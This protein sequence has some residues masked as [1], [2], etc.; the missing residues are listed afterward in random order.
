[1]CSQGTI[2]VD[3]ELR[4]P[5]EVVATKPCFVSLPLAGFKNDALGLHVGSPNV[6]ER[7]LA[8]GKGQHWWRNGSGGKS[9]ALVHRRLKRVLE[10]GGSTNK[11]WVW[12]SRWGGHKGESGKRGNGP[13]F[14]G[15]STSRHASP[16]A[17][18]I[19]HITYHHHESRADIDFGLRGFY[20]SLCHRFHVSFL[21]CVVAGRVRCAPAVSFVLAEHKQRKSPRQ[22]PR[23]PDRGQALRRRRQA[24]EPKGVLEQG[25]GRHRR[26]RR[27]AV[28]RDGVESSV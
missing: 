1:L 22:N 21:S 20:G 7:D 5:G 14:N 16:N 6:G 28:V 15:P 26:T 27:G 8:N 19:C 2:V 12:L 10:G 4:K 18:R 11:A 17:E 3:A 25:D 24:L 23:E 9:L 13:V